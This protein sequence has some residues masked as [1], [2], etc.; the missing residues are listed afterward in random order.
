MDGPAPDFAKRVEKYP[1]LFFRQME[2]SPLKTKESGGHGVI[3]PFPSIQEQM[4]RGENL[5]RKNTAWDTAFCAV[6]VMCC[7]FHDFGQ[8]MVRPSEFLKL[9]LMLHEE[10]S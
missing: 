1:R 7:Q 9:T 6:T 3:R 8:E 5:P 4:E 2:G 10:I